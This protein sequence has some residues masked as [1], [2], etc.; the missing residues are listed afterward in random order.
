MPISIRIIAFMD[1]GSIVITNAESM[2]FVTLSMSELLR[3]FTA[4]SEYFPLLKIG[5][6]KNKLM[7]WAVLASF[8]LILLVIYVPFLQGIFNTHSLTLLQW[9]EMAPLILL[10]SVAA[11]LLKAVTYKRREKII[12]QQAAGN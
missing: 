11:E 4:R 8:V 9:A 5:V 1:W 12:Q 2:A 3:A 6:F 10:P 7:N